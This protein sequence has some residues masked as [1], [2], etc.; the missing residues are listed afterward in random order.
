MNWRR[1]RNIRLV[2]NMRLT[3]LVMVVSIGLLM[4]GSVLKFLLLMVVKLM[5]VK[6]RRW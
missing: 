2:L 6:I 5:I 3:V 4:L 1:R